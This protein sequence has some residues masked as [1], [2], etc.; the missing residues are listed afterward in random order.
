MVELN[1]CAST[2]LTRAEAK[3]GGLEY[4]QPP[5]P[6][7]TGVWYHGTDKVAR[8][9]ETADD[10]I[11][12]YTFADKHTR[13]A[14]Y[15]DQ[16]NESVTLPGGVEVWVL[17]DGGYK[18]RLEPDV[19]WHHSP[20]RSATPRAARGGTRSGVVSPIHPSPPSKICWCTRLPSLKRSSITPTLAASTMASTPKNTADL[21]GSRPLA[22]DPGRR[23]AA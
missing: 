4:T 7:L 8:V 3:F 17:E 9:H 16:L 15:T 14:R 5:A 1:I 22:D 13:V 2:R 10:A 12:V 19:V 21:R 20:D 6:D 23:E 11:S 18:L